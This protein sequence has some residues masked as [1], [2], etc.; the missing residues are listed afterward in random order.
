MRS[1]FFRL[2]AGKIILR[3]RYK[4]L[5]HRATVEFD[6][7]VT[8]YNFVHTPTFKRTMRVFVHQFLPGV[9]E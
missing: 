7:L 9:R 5:Q 4:A 2:G 8:Y 6:A 3:R 1:L